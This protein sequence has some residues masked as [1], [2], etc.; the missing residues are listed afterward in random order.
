MQIRTHVLPA[1]LLA[2]FAGDVLAQ[3]NVIPGCDIGLL[4]TR[5]I[6]RYRRTG[7]Y[8]NGVMAVGMW[9]T[10]CNPGTYRIPFIAAM[11]AN[12]GFIHYIVARESNGR[13]VQI[14]DRAYVK[15]TFGSNNDLSTCGTC[16]NS[17]GDVN[18]VEI[19]CAD[20][21]A[22]SQAV[23][24]F[25]LGPPDEIDP[26]LGA[27][28]PACSYFDRGEPAGAA[29]T[30][31]D[32]VRSLT[33]TQSQ[34]LNTAINHAT[35][36]YDADLNVAGATFYWQAGYLIPGEAE[37][38]RTNNFGTKQFTATWAGTNWTFA[39]V[40]TML[41]GP[42]LNRWSGATVTSNTNGAD[43]GRFYVGVKVTGPVNGI[44]HYEY[45]VHNRD[46]KRGMGAF[47]IP[48]C[49]AAQVS[50]FGFKDVDTLATNQWTA[51]KVNNEIVYTVSGTNALRWNS[52]YNFWFDSDAAPVA[53]A[54]QL[55]QFDIGPGA[56][57]VAVNTTTPSG[58]Y[59]QFLGAGCGT[60]A[61][62][63]FATGSPNRASLGN[64]TFGL[65]STN[66]PALAPCGFIVSF[67]EGATP[68]GGCTVYTADTSTVLGPMMTVSS[69]TGAASMALTIPSS[70]VFEG[71]NLDMQ[72][73]SF[74]NG[75]AMMG[76]FNLSNGLR[77][78]V[79]SLV[80]SCP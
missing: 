48:V 50:N 79:G 61:P 49:A 31:C 32:G 78:R 46:N 64:N 10:C 67:A 19:G 21:Y 23:D 40:G 29:S 39:D 65:S 54:A 30:L 77:I 24:H 25:N 11:N 42:I 9:T 34:A 68:M 63:L 38:L 27:W 72:L 51:A 45:A 7:T 69:S 74:A 75:G 18:Y 20:T 13:F 16:V 28:V 41:Q 59:N 80:T 55:D 57:S 2:A 37:S 66:N 35:R 14:S 70:T 6:Q 12:H 4:D 73:V 17:P 44:Y 60:P 47:R 22:N 53:G 56:L 76:S 15:H 58:V 3:S 43:D 71:M 33:S 8:P 1:F 26:W 5:T 62:S 52:I 36:V